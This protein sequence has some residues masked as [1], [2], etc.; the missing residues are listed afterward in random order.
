MRQQFEEAD[1]LIINKA[2]LVSPEEMAALK[3]G[4]ESTWPGI[5][6]YEISAVKNQ[7]VAE[8]LQETSEGSSGGRK[9]V[10]MDYETYAS[11]EAE[12]GWLNAAAS[13]AARKE[14]DWDAF[15]QTLIGRIQQGLASHHTEIGHLKILVSN[16]NG[17]VAANVT[18]I[19]DVPAL[20]GSIGTESGSAHLLINARV[21]MEPQLLKSIVERLL[22]SVAG[23]T[24][25]VTELSLDSFK[26]AYPRPTHRF[27]RVVV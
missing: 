17:Q 13:L 5:K 22:R 15:A 12:L 20:Q 6:T 11:G 14:T 26:P 10:P 27:G 9:I 25:E 4:I 19:R 21:L 8:W 16:Q 23:E 24:V 7:G 2:D 1:N 3:A 18:S